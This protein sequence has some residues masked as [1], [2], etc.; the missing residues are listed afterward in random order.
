MLCMFTRR[1][2]KAVDVFEGQPG[3]ASTITYR[4][5]AHEYPAVMMT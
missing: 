3:S 4:A 1:R 5:A 2:I